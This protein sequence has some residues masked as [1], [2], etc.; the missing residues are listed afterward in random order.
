MTLGSCQDWG[1]EILAL[2]LL[3]KW[4]PV[5]QSLIMV[6][7]LTAPYVTLLCR[8][9]ISVLWISVFLT[10][11][12]LASGEVRR[13]RCPADIL[14]EC[15]AP[16]GLGQLTGSSTNSTSVAYIINLITHKACTALKQQS[17]SFPDI[18]KEHCWW[19]A[20]LWSRIDGGNK[21]DQAAQICSAFVGAH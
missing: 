12:G 8:L 7:S 1:L 9:E 14:L 2:M 16:F 17:L 11:H 10:V 3:S 19:K 15:P 20:S 13:H 21:G 5:R 4:A 6:I 18:L